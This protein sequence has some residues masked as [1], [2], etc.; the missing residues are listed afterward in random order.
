[1]KAVR[2]EELRPCRCGKPLGMF[3]Q[4]VESSLAMVDARSAQQAHGLEVLFGGGPAGAV[5]ADAMGPGVK[6]TLA[7]EE[8]PELLTRRLMCLE[9]YSGLVSILG[10]DA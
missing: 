8:R 10:D 9:C 1:M 4:V 3:F 6:V 2:R 7:A 5:M